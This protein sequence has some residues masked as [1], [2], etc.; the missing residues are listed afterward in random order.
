MMD[1]AKQSSED[2]DF[3]YSPTFN[4]R[5]LQCSKSLVGGPLMSGLIEPYSRS[6][7]RLEPLAHTRTGTPISPSTELRKTAKIQG[8]TRERNVHT[9]L[10]G[11]AVDKEAYYE[12]LMGTDYQ[13]LRVKTGWD[14]KRTGPPS[15]MVGAG[16]PH[17]NYSAISLGDR[18][19]FNGPHMFQSTYAETSQ[20]GL[21]R[22]TASRLSPQ[23]GPAHP[24]SLPF[25]PLLQVHA[26]HTREC[27]CFSV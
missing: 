13:G 21:D 10:Q 18:F 1:A 5:R 27:I 12:T 20:T 26:R 4:V 25:R 8:P 23:L 2:V 6:P 9:H 19:Y 17:R 3:A 14:P 7:S 24:E 11:S 15:V 22:P 16:N